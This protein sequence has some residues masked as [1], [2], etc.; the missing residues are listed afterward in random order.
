MAFRVQI[1]RDPSNKWVVN[2]PILLNGEFGY[3]NDTTLMK[4]GDG[5]TPWNYLPYWK[6]ST[7]GIGPTGA[8]GPVPTLQQLLDNN[9]DLNEGN[10]FQGTDAGTD[11]S[12]MFVTG[13][14]QAAAKQNTG[15]IVNSIGPGAAYNNTGDDLNGFGFGAG[16]NNQGE[17]VNAFGNSAA[18]GNA[19]KN[20][21]AL[22]AQ[23]GLDNTFKNVNLFG[24]HSSADADNQTVFSKWISGITYY[25]GK[26]SF[27]NITADRKWELPD[28]DGTIALQK[29][30]VFTALLTQNGVGDTYYVPGDTN[31]LAKGITYQ[32]LSVGEGEDMTLYGAPNNDPG[33]YFICTVDAPSSIF[34][35]SLSYDPGAPVATVLENT[36]G[37]IW[38]TYSGIGEY[39]ANSNDLFVGPSDK[40]AVFTGTRPYNMNFSNTE[41][42]LSS[43]ALSTYANDNYTTKSNNMLSFTPLEI[44]VYN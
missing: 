33:T 11:N 40:V 18:D 36:I 32:I 13:L 26:L 43:V 6:V 10:N 3:E 20:V 24:Y 5:A 21:N 1:R 7:G 15:N 39:F 30:K 16:S 28:A 12:G 27:N 31:D 23:A 19:A 2:N 38:F 42:E 9:H 35:S 29:Y 17:A 44:R 22:G 37:N 25:L 4:I 41:V 8:T 34:N 14:G